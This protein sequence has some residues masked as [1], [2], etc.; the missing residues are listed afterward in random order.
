MPRRKDLLKLSDRRCAACRPRTLVLDAFNAFSM[1]RGM[2][3][4]HSNKQ[5]SLGKRE[6]IGRIGHSG[7]SR[8]ETNAIEI[9]TRVYLKII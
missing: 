4:A 1:L 6:L 9:I 3:Y 5:N 2:F 7:L 8:R